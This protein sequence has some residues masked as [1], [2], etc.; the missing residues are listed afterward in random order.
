MLLLALEIYYNEP[1]K[2]GLN[3][4]ERN[5]SVEGTHEAHIS[6]DEYRNKVICAF[7]NNKKMADVILRRV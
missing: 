1:E 7:N 3:I 6:H 2:Y 5:F 4:T